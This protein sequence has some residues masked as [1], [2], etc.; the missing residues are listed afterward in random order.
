[1]YPLLTFNKSSTKDYLFNNFYESISMY[2]WEYEQSLTKDEIYY[3]LIESTCLEEYESIED[4]NLLE[5]IEQ[6]HL[7]G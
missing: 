3:F 1:M 6:L 5:W 4:D 7:G 2:D